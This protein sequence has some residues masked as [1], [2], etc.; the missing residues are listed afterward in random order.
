MGHFFIWF[1]FAI[2]LLNG[3]FTVF[4]SRFGAFLTKELWHSIVP[5]SWIH[6]IVL[7]VL[8]CDFDD[9]YT[10]ID[11]NT[12][13]WKSNYPFWIRD[14]LLKHELS[15]LSYWLAFVQL[16]L[17][18]WLTVA[19]YHVLPF[20]LIVVRNALAVVQT[21]ILL[22]EIHRSDWEKL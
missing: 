16:I 6:S 22:W 12:C 13:F 4:L 21:L 11:I 8:T 17:I 2:F 10:F 18:M 14:F 20:A 19:G 3:L 15:I 5:S 1:K 9:S 7:R